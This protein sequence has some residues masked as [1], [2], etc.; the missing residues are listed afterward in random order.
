MQDIQLSPPDLC[1]RWQEQVPYFGTRQFPK[2]LANVLDILHVPSSRPP[3]APPVGIV[4]V[5]HEEGSNP[6]PDRTTSR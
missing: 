4:E 1:A 5:D 2:C 3:N 6:D